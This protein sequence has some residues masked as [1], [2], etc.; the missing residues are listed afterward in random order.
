MRRHTVVLGED[1]DC[2]VSEE[3]RGG[4]LKRSESDQTQPYL[5]ALLSGYTTKKLL[6]PSH[7]IYAANRRCLVV[8][9]NLSGVKH[10]LC[11]TV[12]HL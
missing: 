7:N 2:G 10:D 8:V 9:P 5:P 1:V 11:A 6:K 3:E 4:D 12:A